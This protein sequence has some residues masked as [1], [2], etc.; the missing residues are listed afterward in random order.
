[1]IATANHYAET[2]PILVGIF[3]QAAGYGTAALAYYEVVKGLIGFIGLLGG[4]V[5]SVC[6]A[7]IM[8]RKV[9]RDNGK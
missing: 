4:A 3:A 6:T 7:I 1:M 9:I 5:A 8:L 2:K